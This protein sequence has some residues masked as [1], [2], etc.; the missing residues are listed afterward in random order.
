MRSGQ[1][2]RFSFPP[3][4]DA[5]DHAVRAFGKEAFPEQDATKQSA[6]PRRGPMV[7]PMPK[8]DEG[9]VESIE[10]PPA[11]APAPANGAVV[12]AGGDV[13]NPPK[14]AVKA[15]GKKSAAAAAKTKAARKIAVPKKRKGTSTEE[16][17]SAEVE[18]ARTGATTTPA[19][20]VEV[21]DDGEEVD[22]FGNMMRDLEERAMARKAAASAAAAAPA[23]SNQAMEVDMEVK[24]EGGAVGGFT[25]VNV[26]VRG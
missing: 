19:A 24:K 12:A 6:I 15:T 13:V 26:P 8:P 7:P 22:V 11:P 17:A 1:N 23:G 10:T 2:M 3:P 5:G 9:V 4:A 16:S 20:D 25:A 21:A 14:N 18:V